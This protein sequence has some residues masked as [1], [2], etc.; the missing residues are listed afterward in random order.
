MLLPFCDHL[1]K[2]DVY[3]QT[4]AAVPPCG[5]FYRGAIPAAP[6][7]I[8]ETAAPGS[9]IRE[10]GKQVYGLAALK[11]VESSMPQSK[12]SPAAS[13]SGFAFS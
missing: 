8:A 13:A 11:R 1:F 10:V 6:S 7:A 12:S 2:R 3:A 9:G 5:G 4:I